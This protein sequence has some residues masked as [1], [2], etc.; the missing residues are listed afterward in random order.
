MPHF[1]CYASKVCCK[2]TRVLVRY[3]KSVYSHE[4]KRYLVEE[5]FY[6]LL[7]SFLNGGKEQKLEPGHAGIIA[8]HFISLA[9]NDA[10]IGKYTFETFIYVHS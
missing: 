6:K 7:Q 1:R 5:V 8:K 9:S 3:S 4:E 2:I 10:A